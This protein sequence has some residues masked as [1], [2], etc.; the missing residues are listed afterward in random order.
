MI[1]NGKIEEVGKNIA[2]PAGDA[3]VVDA[4]GKHVYPGLFFPLA[5][6]VW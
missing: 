5:I 4:K 3:T 6:L 1:S 2:V